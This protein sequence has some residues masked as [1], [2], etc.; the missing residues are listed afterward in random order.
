MHLKHY[1]EF[2][3][4]IPH[5]IDRYS[6]SVGL[7]CPKFFPCNGNEMMVQKYR[8][9]FLKSNGLS[10]HIRSAQCKRFMRAQHLYSFKAQS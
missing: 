4:L 7:M 9:E 6:G 2:E 5:K 10:T 3:S 8:L 1:D